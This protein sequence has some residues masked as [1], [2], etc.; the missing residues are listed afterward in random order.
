MYVLDAQDQ[1]TMEHRLHGNILFSSP[2]LRGPFSRVQQNNSV[3]VRLCVCVLYSR[4]SGVGYMP[5]VGNFVFLLAFQTVCVINL[6][7]S[8]D[9]VTLAVSTT[10]TLV[11]EFL[12]T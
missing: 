6:Q 1:K 2:D 10:D 7:L 5:A 3:Y 4:R 8:R 9:F 12:I 11:D